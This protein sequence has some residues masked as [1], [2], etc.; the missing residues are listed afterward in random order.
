M[1]SFFYS[2]KNSFFFSLVKTKHVFYNKR[3]KLRAAADQFLLC[4]LIDGESPARVRWHKYVLAF[5]CQYMKDIDT[6]QFM[7]YSSRNFITWQLRGGRPVKN[8][9]KTIRLFYR[10]LEL[11]NLV[12]HKWRKSRSRLVLKRRMEVRIYLN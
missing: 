12:K 7:L 6:S 5:F 4:L 8:Y 2:K 10:W 9:W 1:R 3:M 11:Q